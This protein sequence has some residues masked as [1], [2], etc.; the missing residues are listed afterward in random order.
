MKQK[1]SVIT[2]ICCI[3]IA[4]FLLGGTAYAQDEDLPD[5]GITP[6]SPFY[7]VDNWGKNIS[8]F[9]TFGPEAKVRKALK[10]A[11]ERLA[12]AQAMAVKNRV[13]EM[14][15]ATDEYNGLM[16]MVNKRA[17]EAIQRGASD[18]I[19]ETVA[20]ASVKIHAR[21][22]KLKDKL[23]G[24]ARKDIDHDSDN[25]T[26]EDAA[27]EAAEATIAQASELS[28]KVQIKA[29][30]ALARTKPERALDINEAIIQSR[31]NRASIKAADNVTDEAVEALEAAEKLAEIENEIEKLVQVIGENTT[32]AR[33]L[34]HATSNRLEVL[35]R[36]YEKAP[37]AARPAIERAMENSVSKYERAAEKLKENNVLGS[38]PQAAPIPPKVKEEIRERLKLK[39]STQDSDNVTPPKMTLVE[40]KEKIREQLS[41]QRPEKPEPVVSGNKTRELNSSRE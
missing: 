18:N 26:G 35:T 39:A 24:K 19:S 28:M 20:S 6:D 36:V 41:N 27:I 21:L 7:F 5:P 38:L 3:L 17:E 33:K 1:K 8:L 37:E 4:S 30:L 25:E 2:L 12:E 29:L 23:P 14:I 13:R 16:T 31:L 11:E 10:Y 9:F 15:R 34:A 32:L 40:I 22:D